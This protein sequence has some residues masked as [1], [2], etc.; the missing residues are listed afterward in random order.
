ML[1]VENN[2]CV[3]QKYYSLE[4]GRIGLVRTSSRLHFNLGLTIQSMIFY[5]L[6]MEIKV[7]CTVC[8]YKA[9]S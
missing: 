3:I 4:K 9:K 5:G 2:V 8:P 1:N 6:K 7:K